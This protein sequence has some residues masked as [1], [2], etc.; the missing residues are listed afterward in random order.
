MADRVS[1][2]QREG[3]G[4]AV[5]G[6][7]IGDQRCHARQYEPAAIRFQKDLLSAMLW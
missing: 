7:Q 3:G 4:A 5:E 1:R 2:R 6:G